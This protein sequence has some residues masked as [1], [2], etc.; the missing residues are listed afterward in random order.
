MEWEKLIQREKL[1]DIKDDQTSKYKALLN[2]REIEANFS[3]EQAQ[4]ELQSY[5]Q[6]AFWVAR[7]WWKYRP[8]LPYLYFL[9][10]VENLEVIYFFKELTFFKQMK[11]VLYCP[12]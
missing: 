3:E 4:K 2:H 1:Q 6:P 11:F 12:M 9:A 7:R 10:K 8:K 5:K